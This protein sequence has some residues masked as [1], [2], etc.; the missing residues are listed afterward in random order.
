VRSCLHERGNFKCKEN[1]YAENNTLAK[2]NRITGTVSKDET[3]SSTDNIEERSLP[4]L[5]PAVVGAAHLGRFPVS[6]L[7]MRL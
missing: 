3:A 1:V 2:T 7:I 4:Y 6:L 5:H